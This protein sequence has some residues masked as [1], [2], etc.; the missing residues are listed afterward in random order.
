MDNYVSIHLSNKIVII[1]LLK[2]FNLYIIHDCISSNV[3][4]TKYKMYSR[5]L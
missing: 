5:M 4:I 1:T 2:I 3:Q